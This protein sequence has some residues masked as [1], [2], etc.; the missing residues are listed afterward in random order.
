MSRSG[1]APRVPGS[2]SYNAAMWLGLV[3]GAVVL[4][5]LGLAFAAGRDMAS[6]GRQGW[7]F[8]GLVLFAP[9]IGIVVWL[10]SRRVAAEEWQK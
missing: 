7:A 10:L 5:H 1:R 9:I 6:R 8:A 3:V 2:P 4:I